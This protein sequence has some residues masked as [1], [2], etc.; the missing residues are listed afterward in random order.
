MTSEDPIDKA[1]L[2]SDFE[3]FLHARDLVDA[4]RP[5]PAAAELAA[6][7]I[8]RQE[9]A[10]RP[11]LVSRY[12]DSRCDG[13]P[14]AEAA[15][16]CSFLAAV[17]DAIASLENP[18]SADVV[19]LFRVAEDERAAV[20]RAAA[21][22]GLS[23]WIRFRAGHEIEAAR[24]RGRSHGL[25]TV[26]D[27]SERCSDDRR[28]RILRRWQADLHRWASADCE[29]SEPA[30]TPD[31]RSDPAPN[32]AG[33]SD[34]ADPP[35]LS[36]PPAGFIHDFMNY[37]LK[38]A[39]R[40][41]PQLAVATACAIVGT[42]AGRKL[43]DCQQTRMNQFWIS[44]AGTGSGKEHSRTITKE[45]FAAINRT[46][47]LSEGFSS[48]QAI[49]AT[50]GDQP[51]HLWLADE[52]GRLLAAITSLKSG[53]WE[54]RI[55]TDV[56]KLYSSSGSVFISD[57]YADS[58]R[59][60]R[61]IIDRP[62]LNLFAT[63]VPTNYFAALTGDASHDGSLNRF[64]V[65]S[66]TDDLPPLQNPEAC[67]LPESLAGWAQSW[68]DF[69][70]DGGNLLPPPLVAQTSPEAGRMLREYAQYCDDEARRAGPDS[71]GRGLWVR[72]GEKC[73]KLALTIGAS[74]ALP[75]HR[76]EIDEPA[77]SWS[78]EI[79]DQV[80][81]QMIR[82]ATENIADSD[83]QRNTQRIAKIIRD[84]GRAGIGQSK[85]TYKLR[86]SLKSRE[87]T[88]SVQSL[89]DSGEVRV[90]LIAAGN[91]RQKSVMIASEFC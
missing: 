55:L 60:P 90:Q 25:A 70:P 44:L 5:L 80:T 10:A 7:G 48:G 62:N 6:A 19:Q 4:E 72:S 34:R 24:T 71:I 13:M 57:G 65:F 18:D 87:I 15:F 30:A 52:F 58:R 83:F 23:H 28:L 16:R 12:L 75:S 63:T 49:V 21:V 45:L 91:G 3:A 31:W 68:S 27:G 66:V 59:S 9:L 78:I 81:R 76:P 50:V 86:H 67:V 35:A 46:E 38:T 29:R 17:R 74:R 43:I 89:S 79:V 1:K 84:A 82:D 42:L 41:Q 77:V 85:L 88:D 33:G 40:R 32:I 64:L 56:M 36:N 14:A 73:R 54:R 11:D 47:I 51:E 20:K 69:Q 26:R 22:P 53:N 39:Y 61:R 37:C 2:K 8:E